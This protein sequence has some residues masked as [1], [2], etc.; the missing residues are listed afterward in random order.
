MYIWIYIYISLYIFIYLHSVI[1][2]NQM[3]N[4]RR[5]VHIPFLQAA[6]N[7]GQLASSQTLCRWLHNCSRDSIALKV[8]PWNN[9]RKGLSKASQWFQYVSISHLQYCGWIPSWFADTKCYDDS[10]D[11]IMNFWTKTKVSNPGMFPKSQPIKPCHHAS[12]AHLCIAQ[13]LPG[14]K[15]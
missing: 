10:G 5:H 8:R 11:K 2:L 12:S 1:R 3:D 7:T 6:E 13:R 14:C 15:W 4:T 9:T